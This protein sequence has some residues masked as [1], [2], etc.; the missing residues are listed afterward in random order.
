MADSEK[1]EDS[2]FQSLLLNLDENSALSP[3]PRDKSSAERHCLLQYEN[4]RYA[5]SGFAEVLLIN[6]LEK[7]VK[8]KDSHILVV[9]E[10]N[11]TFALAFAVFRNMSWEGITATRCEKDLE[12]AISEVKLIAFEQ[13]FK[14][15][16]E[17]PT[18]TPKECY[19]I[20]EGIVKLP[21][22]PPDCWKVN[23]DATKI[24]E[25]LSV[26]G[27]IVWFQCPWVPRERDDDPSTH[28]LIHDFLK[29]MSSNQ[30]RGNFTVIGIT[31]KFPYVKTYMLDKITW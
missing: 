5:D 26:K 25:K 28:N 27:K 29:H 30:S 14:F 24:A 6:I 9:G 23:I 12:P 31:F 7:L 11:F 20:F 16:R 1:L 21:P 8:D 10:Q 13:Q 18:K 15:I 3:Y 22:P 17:D 4:I 19:P 2:E